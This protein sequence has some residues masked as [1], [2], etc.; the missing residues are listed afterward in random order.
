MR[1]LCSDRQNCSHNVS[2][3]VKR[4]RCVSDDSSSIHSLK[5]RERTPNGLRDAA[6]RS[7]G[8]RPHMII[9][10]SCHFMACVARA[11]VVTEDGPTRKRSFPGASDSIS[12]YNQD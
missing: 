4:I 6:K 3:K 11:K 5:A 9:A 10:T 7:H 2:Q 8:G 1:A 12:H